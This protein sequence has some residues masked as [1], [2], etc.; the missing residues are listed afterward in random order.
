MYKSNISMTKQ[1]INQYLYD[2]TTYESNI[3]ITTQHF[4]TISLAQNNIPIK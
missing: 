1:Y 2:N 4:N 3:S